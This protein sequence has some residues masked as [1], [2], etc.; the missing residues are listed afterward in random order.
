VASLLVAAALTYSNSFSG[1]FIFDDFG[2]IV[3]NTQIRDSSDWRR[4][5]SPAPNTP[6]SGRPLA[7]LSFAINYAAGGLD[8]RGYHLVNLALHLA[9]GLLVFG[10]VRRTLELP[11]RASPVPGR[12]PD[13]ALAVALLWTVHPLNSEVVDYLTQRTES[14]MA[15]CY[16]LTMYA[17]VRA[18]RS[19]HPVR[20]YATAVVSCLV[21]MGS[22]ETIASAPLM[23]MLYD[24]AF[25]F[26]SFRAALNARWRFYAALVATWIPLG[27]LVA[28]TGQSF[29]AGFNTARVSP[30]LYFLNQ[31]G[32]LTRYLGLTFWPQPL[33]VYYG[34]PVTLTVSDVW[35]YA[36]F[37]GVLLAATIV[38]LVRAPRLGFLG[39]WIFVTLAP[40]SSVIPIATEVGAERRMYLPL[41]ALIALIV[42]AAVRLWE[43]VRRRVPRASAREMAP[44]TA[45]LV[46]TIV[47][48]P[49]AMRT[50]A[51]NRE[52]AS[53]LTMAETVL[54]RWP[55]PNAHQLVGTELGALGR[56][57]EAI[58]HLREAVR[59]Y[60]PA[61]YF[62]GSQLLALGRI[63]EAVEQLEAFI[64]EEPNVLAARNA[65][66]LLANALAGQQKFGEA[67]SHY[68]GYLEAHP[69][70]SNAW[71]GL[72]IALVSTGHPAD[73]ITAFRNAVATG[74]GNVRFRD[75]LARALMDNGNLTEAADLARDTA[76]MDPRNPAPHDIIGRVFAAQGK[77][78]EARQAFQ[79][80][81]AIDPN[82]VPALDG[83]RGLR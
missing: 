64:R 70:D 79:R 77:V 69:E 57:E 10:L 26:D 82:Y 12:P 30:W 6:L 58:V 47:A 15:A 51:R 3:Q 4:V 38:A 72:G 63:D 36:L 9:C 23:V 28:H 20:W 34:W 83:L 32:M 8:V 44:L 55:G 50:Y 11:G 71:S 65:H 41:V 46:V 75:N 2:S 19:P 78:D 43:R 22:K 68:R 13:L 60:P 24:R 62:L 49:L 25:V 35:P 59:G 54:A 21:G 74:P 27:L 33:V 80:A 48:L 52:Y 45:A 81:L 14:L 16:L 66:G 73:A 7:N 18:H 56:R 17:S 67:I 29:S 37:I 76:T 40:T 5:L 61:R 31:P 1:P 53:G 42:I 39:A